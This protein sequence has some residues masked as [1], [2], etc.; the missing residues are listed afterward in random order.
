MF[1]CSYL[2]TPGKKLR[3]IVSQNADNGDRRGSYSTFHF[4]ELKCSYLWQKR[5]RQQSRA[6]GAG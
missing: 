2:I 4:M 3:E 5:M 6:S 1:S